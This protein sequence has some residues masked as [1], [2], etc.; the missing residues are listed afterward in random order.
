MT[1]LEARIGHIIKRERQKKKLTL[2]ALGRLVGANHATL[3]NYESGRRRVPPQRVDDLAQALGIDPRLIDPI[4]EQDAEAP[5]VTREHTSKS[6]AI[7]DVSAL[8][9]APCRIGTKI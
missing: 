8:V 2:D 5:R 6:D 9:C 3:T 1:L 7:R 4:A